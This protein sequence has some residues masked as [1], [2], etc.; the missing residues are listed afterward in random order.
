[1][2]KPMFTSDG[3]TYEQDAIREW[4]RGH[5]T[6]PRTG[7]PLPDKVLRPN[8]ALRAQI[9]DF[10][11]RHGLPRAQP[12]DPNPETVPTANPTQAAHPNGQQGQALNLQGITEVLRCSASHMAQAEN[13]LQLA[14]GRR[15]QPRDVAARLQRNPRACQQVMAMVTANAD[16]SQLFLRGVG[17][18]AMLAHAPPLVR[19]T[20]EGNVRA[21]E[22]LLGQGTGVAAIVENTSYAVDGRTL[23]HCA[24]W[25]NH[26]AIVRLLLS[27]GVDPNVCDASRGTALHIAAFMGHLDV[28]KALV[29]NGA[30]LEARS[31]GGS[32]PL[33]R[34]CVEGHSEV[35]QYLLMHHADVLSVREDGTTTLHQ[36]AY[37]GHLNTCQ[38]LLIQSKGRKLLEALD[39]TGSPPLHCA[40]TSGSVEVVRLLLSKD[41]DP[42][43]AAKSGDTALHRAVWHGNAEVAS[44]LLDAAVDVN[45]SRPDGLSLLHIAASRDDVVL[46]KALLERGADMSKQN[47]DG[48]SA[49]HSATWFS[50]ISCALEL[51]NAGA[52]TELQS[53]NHSTALHFAC[54][55]GHAQV[56]RALL[57]KG[58]N[59][60]AQTKDGDTALHQ[61]AFHCHTSCV[62]LLLERFGEELMPESAARPTLSSTR[63]PRRKFVD[64]QKLDGSTALHLAAGLGHL[65]AVDSLLS[66]GADPTIEKCGGLQALELARRA[67]AAPVVNR[68]Q[69]AVDMHQ[70]Q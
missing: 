44:L 43:I 11:E 35:V 28:A 56:V 39:I 20:H 24:A 55:N 19:A 57:A 33:H 58:A 66:Y 29:E 70:Q 9:V 59:V 5:N 6:S 22:Q 60:F 48:F 37:R 68:L 36:A 45:V 12:W 14:G 17:Q 64:A 62:V 53:S 21:V 34:A 1:M 31:Q 15:H 51:I 46:V 54:W 25:A 50:R 16:V 8:H 49:L 27:K 63:A 52:P 18:G 30:N 7:E 23:L 67:N 40:A 38:L 10:R 2:Q 69:A 3:H 4:L 42:T 13:L 41:V 47:A 26:P 61:A 65:A 32:T